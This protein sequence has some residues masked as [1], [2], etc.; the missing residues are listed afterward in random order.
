[1]NVFLSLARQ[2]PQRAWQYRKRFD[3]S[4]AVLFLAVFFDRLTGNVLHEFLSVIFALACLYHGFL[5]AYWY[6]NLFEGKP[7]GS[8]PDAALLLLTRLVNI[9]LTATALMSFVTG[10]AVSQSLLSFLS[11]EQWRMSLDM[12]TLHVGWS[13]WF[14]VFLSLHAGLNATVLMGA[15]GRPQGNRAVAFRTA[16]SLVLVAAGLFAYVN[17]HV[18]DLLSF[19]NAFIEVDRTKSEIWMPLDFILLFLGLAATGY[20]LRNLLSRRK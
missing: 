20:L 13:A 11:P 16:G 14:F 9:G 7:S 5:N 4:L 1:M 10:V 8:K 2:N 17:R 6:G 3:Y 19:Y 15:V 12:R 18:V